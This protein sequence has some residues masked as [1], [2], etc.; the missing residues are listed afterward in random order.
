MKLS[1]KDLINNNIICKED[2]LA[3]L[4]DNI[5]LNEEDEKNLYSWLTNQYESVISVLKGDSKEFKFIQMAD[6]IANAFS[7]DGKCNIN[8]Y[9]IKIL[10]PFIEVFPRYYKDD[11]IK[12]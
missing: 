5:E 7:K 12:E 4:I 6:M 9:D 2:K 3:F 8:G 10:N 11:Y 1:K